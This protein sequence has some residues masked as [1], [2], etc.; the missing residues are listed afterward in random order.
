MKIYDIIS[1]FR[2]HPLALEEVAMT[3]HMGLPYLFCDSRFGDSYLYVRFLLHKEYL[4]D[5][6]WFISSPTQMVEL[7]CETGRVRKYEVFHGFVPGHILYISDGAKYIRSTAGP[8]QKL[9]DMCNEVLKQFE[10]VLE[11]QKNRTHSF[12]DREDSVFKLEEMVDAYQ[13][14]FRETVKELGQEGLY[15]IMYDSKA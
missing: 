8:M 15:G 5:G 4:E 3:A 9:Y 14:Q 1:R 13:I 6:R 12:Q 10:K 7:C 11:L 2:K